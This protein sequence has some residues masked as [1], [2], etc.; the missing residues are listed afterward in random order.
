MI[1]AANDKSVLKDVKE[2]LNSKFGMKDLGKLTHFLGIDFEQ[3]GGH[4]K[5]SQDKYVQ[6]LLERFLML[7]YKPRVTP[8]EQ[9]LTT[10]KMQ[11]K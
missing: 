1:V 8:C 10:V 4:I 9:N 11:K 6:R 7:D 5:M 3:T 2:M